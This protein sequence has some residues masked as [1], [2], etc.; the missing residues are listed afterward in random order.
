[1]ASKA[2]DDRIADEV[3]TVVQSAVWAG[4]S[5]EKFR[6]ACASAWDEVM[7]QEREHAAKDW[8]APR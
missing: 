6:R 7:R 8:Q 2:T 5:V 1:M 3:Y 4:W